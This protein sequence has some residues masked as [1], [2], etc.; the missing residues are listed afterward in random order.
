MDVGPTRAR[1]LGLVA[2]VDGTDAPY[3][4][5]PSFS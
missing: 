4:R 3:M 5:F 1:H 2:H